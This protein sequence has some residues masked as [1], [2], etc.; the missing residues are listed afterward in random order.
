MHLVD[1]FIQ[2][3]FQKSALQK[4]IGPPNIVGSQNM[5]HALWKLNKSQMEE[6]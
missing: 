2:S 6:P 4:C 1:A 5:K 3:D